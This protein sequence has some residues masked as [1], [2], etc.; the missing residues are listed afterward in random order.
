MPVALKLNCVNR[1]MRHL[2]SHEA[3]IHNSCVGRAKARQRRAD[4]SISVRGADGGHASLCPP[5]DLLIPGANWSVLETLIAAPPPGIGSSRSIFCY[6]FGA[7][8]VV[9]GNRLCTLNRRDC[10]PCRGRAVA[11]RGGESSAAVHRSITRG[12]NRC[13]G[14]FGVASNRPRLRFLWSG[15][16]LRRFDHDVR[17]RGG[18]AARLCCRLRHCCAA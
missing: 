4:Q 1:A 10:G 16:L 13:P 12:C 5:Y 17:K 18:G 11:G 9:V 7:F 2:S 3:R 8:D 15:Y 6:H 14:G